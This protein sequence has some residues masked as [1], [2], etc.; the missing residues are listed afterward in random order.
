MR[1]SKYLRTSAFVISKIEIWETN[2]QKYLL[3]VEC[4]HR[5]PSYNK[6]IELSL[7]CH[8]VKQ[9]KY[10]ANIKEEIKFR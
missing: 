8:M 5:C 9:L 2:C 7:D 10:L 6:L 1:K 3:A 4:T